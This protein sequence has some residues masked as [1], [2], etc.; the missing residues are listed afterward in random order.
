MYY[1]LKSSIYKIKIIICF[2]CNLLPFNNVY[3]CTKIS[4]LFSVVSAI[5]VQ[6]SWLHSAR[7]EV[8]IIT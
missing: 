1:I 4:K 2:F 7:H 8:E 6:S 5:P 3:F